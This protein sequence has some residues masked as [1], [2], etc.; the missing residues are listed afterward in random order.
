MNIVKRVDEKSK[1]KELIANYQNFFDTVF[2]R[3]IGEYIHRIIR[4]AQ[5][6]WDSSNY[7]IDF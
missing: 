7:T 6:I 3:I 4:K 1:I 2:I 5:I